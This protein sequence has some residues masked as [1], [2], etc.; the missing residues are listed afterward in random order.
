MN[1]YYSPL[2]YD[3]QDKYD[4][5]PRMDIVNLIPESCESV[6]EIGCGTGA[7]GAFLKEKNPNLYYVGMEI[8]GQAA[9]IAKTRLNEVLTIDI[10]K[11]N[12]DQFNL[13]KNFFDLIIAADVLEH[14]YDPWRIMDFLRCFIEKNGKVILSFPNTQN[15]NL[16]ANLV[17]GNWTYEKYGLLDATHIR[18]FTWNEI[19]KLLMGTGYRILRSVSNLQTSLDGHTFPLEISISNLVFKNVSREEAQKLFTFQY[20]VLAE[21]VTS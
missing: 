2:H 18:F 19:E 13:K 8:D 16:I 14:L 10:E 9:R 21:K 4:D 15:I 1:T 5:Q 7:T 12:A 20:L 3:H 11:I 17:Q 6:L